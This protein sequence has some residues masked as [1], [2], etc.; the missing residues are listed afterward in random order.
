MY[1]IRK[2]DSLESFVHPGLVHR[3]LA[4]SQH[5]KSVEVWMQTATPGGRT[6]T[7]YHSGEEVVVVLRGSGWCKIEDKQL[8]FGPN[9]VIT[10]PPNTFHQLATTGDEDLV[11]IAILQTPVEVFNRK[12][13]PISLPWPYGEVEALVRPTPGVSE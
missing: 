2:I 10:V 3:T 4:G 8:D 12:G 5:V 6:P 7:H 9:S 11:A 1:S 13:E